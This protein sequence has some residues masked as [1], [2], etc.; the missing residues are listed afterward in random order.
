MSVYHGIPQAE[1]LRGGLSAPPCPAG[2]SGDPPA[3][4]PATNVP[5]ALGYKFT[6]VPDSLL[7]LIHLHAHLD[8]PPRESD[9][10]KERERRRMLD[11]RLKRIDADVLGEIIGWKKLFRASAWVK[12]ET[13][14]KA[15]GVS[16]KTVQRSFRRLEIHGFI[17]QV[18]VPK[19]DPD[20]PKNRTG[21]RI[22]FLFVE[23]TDTPEPIPATDR[24]TP[25]ERKVWA[26]I[27][28]DAEPALSSEKRTT[29]SSRERTTVSSN[30]AGASNRPDLRDSDG[31]RTI[32]RVES[33]VWA[34]PRGGEIPS[35]DRARA[36]PIAR[37]DPAP[38]VQ[39]A[40]SPADV[41]E[42]AAAPSPASPMARPAPTSEAE[43]RAEMFFSTL[44]QGIG[45]A[46]RDEE[47]NGSWK[48]YLRV[49]SETLDP[50][51]ILTLDWIMGLIRFIRT[52]PK[53]GDYG[54]RF[55]RNC[56]AKRQ[57]EKPECEVVKLPAKSKAS[58]ASRPPPTVEPSV[59]TPPSPEPSAG[60][61]EAPIAT[62][63]RPAPEVIAEVLGNVAGFT[64]AE[65]AGRFRDKMRNRELVPKRSGA[66]LEFTSDGLVA[67]MPLTAHSQP[68]SDSERQVLRWL[69]ADLI[70]ALGGIPKPATEPPPVAK[71]DRMTPKETEVFVALRAKLAAKAAP[72]PELSAEAQPTPQAHAVVPIRA[73]HKPSSRAELVARCDE[74]RAWLSANPDNALAECQR[75]TLAI[76]EAK[77]AAFDVPTA[78][79]NATEKS[80]EVS[81]R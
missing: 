77:L 52:S 79:A 20:Q 57:G 26:R 2:R 42:L 78:T 29:V 21:W 30:C 19:P 49:A 53:T 60:R 11:D 24:R 54:K 66:S 12:K 38:L 40:P 63:T 17:A 14:A 36:A 48:F 10:A 6:A 45:P 64:P 23:L 35:P 50:D 58:A 51:K 74:L 56:Q 73:T 70:S 5:S 80:H 8:V 28:A 55:T 71:P 69:N 37:P 18:R 27:G 76:A 15:L 46:R 47:R 33:N 22:H 81:T 7:D 41:A 31:V 72:I 13:I 9:P 65:L 68:F 44:W 61:S 4:R 59:S 3:A 1:R 75:K 32:D 62:A 34:A 43:A 25:S 39:A 67:F 16:V